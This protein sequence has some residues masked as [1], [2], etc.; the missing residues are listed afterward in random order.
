MKL[1]LDKSCK[2]CEF[3][4]GGICLCGEESNNKID[5]LSYFCDD[6][7]IDFEYYDYIITKLPWY[8]KIKFEQNKI[9]FNQLLDLIELD[10][11]DSPIELNIFEVVEKIYG[12]SYPNEI[13]E[14]LGVTAG[15]VSYAYVHGT[16]LKRICDFS[17]KLCIPMNYFE[18]ITTVDICE[19]I[20][21]K[22]EFL[23]RHGGSLDEIKANAD[24]KLEKAELLEKKLNYPAWKKEFDKKVQKYN[25]LTNF[26]HDLSDDYKMRDYVV[27]IQFQKGDYKGNIYYE[28]SYSGY[29][30]D[31]NIMRGL[32]QFVNELDAETINEY[33]DS[34]H[35][36][37]DMNMTA[38]VES[39]TIY[40][41][42]HNDKDESLE[43]LTNVENLQKYIVGYKMI[44]CIGY[45]KKKE[46]RKCM[47]CNN[48]TPSQTSAKGFCSVRNENVQRSRI[49]CGFDF[50]PKDF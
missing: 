25:A 50:V 19:I 47:E 46:R 41:V 20:E 7:E 30:L 37:N 18:K 3:F 2:T 15:V 38:D 10:E 13:A 12:L 23:K 29:G 43:V 34:C 6:W 9:N 36:I 32:L 35:L 4:S 26:N 24:E 22:K 17:N 28:Y 14:V 44:D 45:G 11:Q 8:L 40:L 5:N 31:N 27:S 21:C 49:I 16:P 33:N 1:H 48:F 39:D 42:L